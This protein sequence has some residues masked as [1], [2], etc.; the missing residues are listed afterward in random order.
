M[1][2]ANRGRLVMFSSA[3]ALVLLGLVAVAYGVG[4]H[5]VV[6]PGSVASPHAGIDT[7]CAQCHQPAKAATDLRCERCHDPIDAHR[8]GSP[9]HAALGGG[10]AWPAAHVAQVQCAVCH[11]EHGGR[12][13]DLKLVA[14]ERC[15][16]CRIRALAC[17]GGAGHRDRFLARDP[18]A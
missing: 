15:T 10:G 7:N 6:S 2:P 14:D 11:T 3:A 8:F 9:A 5:G 1:M 4:M 12:S 16:S 17:E 13:R 18:P